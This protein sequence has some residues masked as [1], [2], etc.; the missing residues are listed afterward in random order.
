MLYN[1]TM[2]QHDARA[3]LTNTVERLERILVLVFQ[4]LYDSVFITSQ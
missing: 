3:S 1:I 2:L 4:L